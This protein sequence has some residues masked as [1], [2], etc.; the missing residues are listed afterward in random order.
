MRLRFLAYVALLVVGCGGSMPPYDYSREPDPRGQEFVIGPLDVLQ[1]SVWKNKE[2]SADAAVVRPDGVITLPLIGDVKAAGRTPSAV[3][4]EIV[5]R[6][7]AYIQPEEL[8][9]SVAVTQVNSYHFTVMGAVERGGYFTSRQYVT[10]LEALALA[11]GPNRFAGNTLYILRGKPQ[12]KIPIDI[13]RA[14]SGKH[15]NENLVVLAGDVLV[16]Q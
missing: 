5:Q 1:V 10:A 13:K 14:T 2:L 6:L 15:D 7:S 12:R 16:L 9:V 8:V 11:G 3:R 4:K